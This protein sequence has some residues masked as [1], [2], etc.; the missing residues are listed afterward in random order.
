[1]LAHVASSARVTRFTPRHAAV[2]F[3]GPRGKGT[4]GV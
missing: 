3:R 1:M 4:V 2:S